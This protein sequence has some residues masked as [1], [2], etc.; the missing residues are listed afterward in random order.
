[1][2]CLNL[3]KSKIIIVLNKAFQFNRVD[4][5]YFNKCNNL[6]DILNHDLMNYLGVKYHHTDFEGSNFIAIGSVLHNI[7]T[8]DK[9]K[10]HHLG[11]LDIWGSGFI[12]PEKSEEEYFIKK[13]RISALR[14][15]ISKVRCEKIL[16]S[17]LDTV[18]LGDP[19]LL[20]SIIFPFENI[21]KKY[22]VGIVPHYIDKDSIYLKKIKL[23]NKS[24]K[25]IDVQGKV[26]DICRE[27]KEC[28][29]ILSSSLHGLVIADSYDIPN[30]WIKLS[31]DLIG[32]NYKFNDYYSVFDN[33]IAEPY[34]LREKLI[35][36]NEISLF[37]A[38][39]KIK[40]D[41]IKEICTNL[42]RV[43][44][45]KRFSSKRKILWPNTK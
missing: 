31:D 2:K 19:G 1:M 36:D 41:F 37:T 21:T 10:I 16:K 27:I 29:F 25:I 14:G 18:V 23:D 38:S 24:Y 35:S 5:A 39:Y 7:I 40:K 26:E 20:V 34:D 43:F 17:N 11:S 30:K 22:D 32:G 42:L 3:I 28:R 6:G 9:S 15:K 8:N 4:F 13:V 12:E 45:K 33:E 44:P